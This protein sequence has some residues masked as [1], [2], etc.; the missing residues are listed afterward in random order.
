M[1]RAKKRIGRITIQF[2][3]SES[4]MPPGEVP[5]I[6]IV[7][8]EGYVNGVS[9]VAANGFKM[10]N[11]GEKN[12]R[13][14]SRDGTNSGMTFQITQTRKPL[15]FVSKIVKQGKSSDLLSERILHSEPSHRHQHRHR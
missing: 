14:S 6:P 2:G 3:A 8:S 13:F 11:L 4:V 12:A 9:Y 5:E 15:A 10:P 7:E 1:D